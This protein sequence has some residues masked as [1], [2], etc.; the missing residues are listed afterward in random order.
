M[1]IFKSLI[2]ISPM[3]DIKIENSGNCQPEI[4]PKSI[5]IA[6]FVVRDCFMISKYD[7]TNYYD[8]LCLS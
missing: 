7:C 3:G 4:I 8:A 1:S 6:I 2:N 5:P